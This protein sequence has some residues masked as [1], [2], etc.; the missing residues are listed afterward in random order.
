MT[1][2]TG[3]ALVILVA[4]A[5]ILAAILSN[6]LTDRLRVPAPAVFLVGA[7]LVATFVPGLAQALPVQTVSWVVTVALV[8]ILFDGGMSIGWERFRSATGPILWVGVLG[9]AATAGAVAGLA[10]LVFGLPWLPAL[11]LG[12][13]LSPTDPAVVFSVLGHREVT[14]RSGTLL[15]GEAGVNDPVGIALMVSLIAGVGTGVVSPAPVFT[16]FLVQ[17]VVGAAVGGC[18]GWLLL[19]TM[20]RLPLPTEGLYPLRA[21]AGALFLYGAATLADG[22]GFLAVF[23]AGIVIGDAWVPY[24]RDVEQFHSALASLSEIVAFLLLGLTIPLRTLPANNAWVM[25]LVLA[26]LLAFLVRPVLVGLLLVPIRLRWGERVFVM[27]SG[28]KGAVPILLGVFALLGA[29]PDAVRIYDA[30]F[31]VVAV[32]VILQGSLVPLVANRAG[33]PMRVVDL[34]PWTLGLRFRHR[35]EGVQRFQVAPGSPANGSRVAELGVGRDVWISF[36]VRQGRLVQ[37]RG[38]TQ[39]QAGDEVLALVDPQCTVDLDAI[40][41]G[42][43]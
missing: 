19:Q 33:V 28:L 18:G 31:V 16:K 43:A 4:A 17:M 15:E 38:D 5:V 20:R 39:L 12:T 27:W 29:V 41:E 11:V 40:F 8:M 42:S 35:P 10:H 6:R 34:T 37:V 36:V 9:T 24:K 3:F 2:V 32:S 25:G 13:A 1:G 14:G 7:A 30:I 22:S 21:L 23:V 26:A